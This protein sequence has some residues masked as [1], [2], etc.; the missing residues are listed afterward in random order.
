MISDCPAYE[1][2]ISL[3]DKS[4]CRKPFSS[5]SLVDRLHTPSFIIVRMSSKAIIS[6]DS[7]ERRKFRRYWTNLRY[8]LQFTSVN[9]TGATY[10]LRVKSSNSLCKDFRN[11]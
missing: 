3:D 9:R 11:V 5:S 1:K 2:D 7:V 4:W 6:T 8:E 10:K